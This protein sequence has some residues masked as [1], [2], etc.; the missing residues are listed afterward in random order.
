MATPDQTRSQAGAPRIP[1]RNLIFSI[2]K[3]G[4]IYHP[5]PVEGTGW[6]WQTHGRCRTVNWT[7]LTTASLIITASRAGVE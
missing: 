6:L 1:P 7:L 3:M 2:C 5:Y 4:L